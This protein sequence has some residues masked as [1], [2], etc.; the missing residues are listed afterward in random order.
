[1][2]AEYSISSTG[3]WREKNDASERLN[4]RCRRIARKI[5]RFTLPKT[6]TYRRVKAEKAHQQWSK[7]QG[8]AVGLVVAEEQEQAEKR[9]GAAQAHG[10]FGQ[11]LQLAQTVS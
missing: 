5:F 11:H 9:L 4:D 8:K 6:W 1:M 7:T 2:S 10:N 3:S